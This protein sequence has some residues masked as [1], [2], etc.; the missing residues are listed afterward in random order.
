MLSNPPRLAPVENS[1]AAI[2]AGNVE[3][4]TTP[5]SCREQCC[6][7]INRFLNTGPLPGISCSNS[8]GIRTTRGGDFHQQFAKKVRE[9]YRCTVTCTPG[10]G[11]E[12]DRWDARLP[13]PKTLSA[14]L[15]TVRYHSGGSMKLNACNL[16]LAHMVY[17]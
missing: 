11:S 4:P 17:L 5:C 9:L 8:S 1:V 15:G 14:L 6:S 3:Q 13:R 10:Y 2:L 12:G 7:L 16:L